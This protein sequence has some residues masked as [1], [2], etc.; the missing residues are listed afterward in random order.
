ME[1]RPEC[2]KPDGG[3]K[4][5]PRL[6]PSA[7]TIRPGLHEASRADRDQTNALSNAWLALQTHRI[8][9]G[10]ASLPRPTRRQQTSANANH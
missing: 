5:R 3:S 10:R 4:R 1:Q 2:G 7:S 9:C 6:R 8:A